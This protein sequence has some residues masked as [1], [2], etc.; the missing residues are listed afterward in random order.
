MALPITLNLRFL[1]SRENKFRFALANFSLVDSGFAFECEF[2][3]KHDAPWGILIT[4]I[5]GGEFGYF[6]N[7]SSDKMQK[8]ANALSQLINAYYGFTN[9]NKPIYLKKEEIVSKLS[10]QVFAFTANEKG[11][12]VSLIP[13]GLTQDVFMNTSI[14][15]IPVF[16]D[17]PAELRYRK[18]AEAANS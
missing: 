18:P 14:S 13:L 5:K 16:A 8:F 15:D 1:D 4:E 6:T 7:L 3:D 11:D 9:A 17:M 12:G 10:E 2:D